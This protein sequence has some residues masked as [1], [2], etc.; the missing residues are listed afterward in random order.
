MAH[1]AQLDENNIV[2][3]IVVVSNDKLIDEKTGKEVE[4]IGINFLKNIFGNSTTWI[5]TSYNSKIRKNYAGIGYTYDVVNDAFYAPQPYPSWTLNQ[6][7]FLWE[8][9]VPCPDDGKNYAW[10]EEKL[11]WEIVPDTVDPS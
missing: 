10:N 8:S 11:I 9:P 6:T 5:Q 1:F 3:Q 7:T 4:Q 2:L